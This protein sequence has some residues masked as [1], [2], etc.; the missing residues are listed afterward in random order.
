M[1]PCK[2]TVTLSH[3]EPLGIQI[4]ALFGFEGVVDKTMPYVTR[5]T[6]L[7]L[8]TKEHFPDQTGSQTIA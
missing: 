4:S 3:D 6:V 8:I 5:M 1:K 7:A 2:V